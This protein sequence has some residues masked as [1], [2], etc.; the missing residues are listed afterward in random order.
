MES[1]GSALNLEKVE[2]FTKERYARMAEEYPMH[3]ELFQEASHE[4]ANLIE[5][6]NVHCLPL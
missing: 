6:N 4:V 5:F 3:A 1:A 2:H